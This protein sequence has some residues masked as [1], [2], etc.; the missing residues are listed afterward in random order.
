MSRA[1]GSSDW[2]ELCERCGTCCFEKIE[3]EHGRIFFTLTPCRYLDVVTRQCKVYERRFKINP[4][5]IKL[6]PAL[7]EQLHWLHDN[8]AYK[9]I[10]AG[11]KE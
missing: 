9:K 11:E 4:E 2:E 10:L 1:K 7:V 5:C 6:T 3:D 8:C